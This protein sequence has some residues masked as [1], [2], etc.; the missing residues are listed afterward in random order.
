MPRYIY[1]LLLYLLLP[2]VPIKLIWR[3]L[4]QPGYLKHWG[5]RFGCYPK[6]SYRDKPFIWLH[7]VSV[8]ETRAA[9]PLV[10]ELQHRYPRHNVLITHG[11]PTGRQTSEQL[12]ADSIERVY[13]PYDVPG[14]VQRFLKH[15]RP[16]VGLLLE[17]ELW[18]NL[19]AACKKNGVPLLLVNARLSQRSADGYARIGKL[20]RQGL[21]SLTGIAAQTE[22][23]ANRL[24]ALGARHV[25]VFGNLK[26]DVRPPATAFENG[27]KL[28]RQLGSTR[29][30]FLAASTRDGEEALILNAVAETGIPDLLTVLVPRHPQRFDEVAGLL[31]RR[32]L[33]FVR[34]SSLSDVAATVPDDVEVVLGDTMGEM[35]TYYASCDIA[36]IG[37][38]LLPFGGQNLIEAAAMGKPHI[39]GPHTFNFEEIANL[40]IASGAALRIGNE[41]ELGQALHQLMQDAALHATMSEAALQFSRKAGGTAEKIAGFVKPYLTSA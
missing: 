10:R 36:F 25:Q 22:A 9:E 4:K 23:D 30:V 13:L 33:N 29:P 7:C 2:L 24:Q 38:S 5:E 14:A 17:T 39:I 34:R 32:G 18:F 15:F 41:E 19:I 37:G 20:T 31:G 35:F 3:G 21:T 16:G 40:A 11:T 12:F 6:A 8:G 1:S 28:R 27:I 26:F